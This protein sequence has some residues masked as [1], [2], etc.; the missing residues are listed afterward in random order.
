MANLVYKSWGKHYRAVRPERPPRLVLAHTETGERVTMTNLSNGLRGVPFTRQVPDT[1]WIDSDVFPFERGRCDR[2]R[3]MRNQDI[4][5]LSRLDA[6]ILR[7]EAL[8]SEAQKQRRS[9][10][11]TAFAVAKP[12]TRTQADQYHKDKQ[13]A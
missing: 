12:I 7:L 11:Q 1:L 9:F 3:I 4:E 8:V 5:T 6:E 13:T 10:L 2:V